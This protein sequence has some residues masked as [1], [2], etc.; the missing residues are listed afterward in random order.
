MDLQWPWREALPV[1]PTAGVRAVASVACLFVAFWW[2]S[3]RNAT[4]SDGCG[5]ERDNGCDDP[6]CLRCHSSSRHHGSAFRANAT[7]LR[8]LARLEPYLFEGMRGDIWS[9]VED[10][11]DKLD[12]PNDDRLGSFARLRKSMQEWWKLR[13][14]TNADA[15]VKSGGGRASSSAMPSSPRE[16]QDPTVFF[17]PGLE[18]VPLHDADRCPDDCPCMRLWKSTPISKNAPPIPVTGDVEALRNGFQIIRGELLDFL[19][20]NGTSSDPFKPF[21]PKVYTH[22]GTATGRS[23]DTT[24]STTDP[25]WSSV[26]LYRQGIRQSETCN[27][28]FPQTAYILETKCPHLMGGKCGFGSVYFSKLRRNTR[29]REHCGPTNVRWRCHLPLIV[30]KRTRGTGAGDDEG[31]GGSR[32]RVGHPGVNERS[33]GWEEGAPLLF[34]DSFLHSA[35]HGGSDDPDSDGKDDA[36]GARIVLIVDLWHPALSD[37]DRTALGVLYPPG[38]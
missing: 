11:E 14:S 29:V 7:M 19:S 6:R 18:A 34:D 3:S 38:S 4:A 21:D 35:V 31:G 36:D 28:H 33:V 8:R 32:L 26:Y 22:A 20:R 5:T 2:R 25:E 9:A 30:P 13:Q 16:G 23:G 37:A 17:L 24:N 1:R 27:E 15:R 12:R 10:M